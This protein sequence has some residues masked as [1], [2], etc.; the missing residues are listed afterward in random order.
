MNYQ[1]LIKAVASELGQ[2]QTAVKDVLDTAIEEIKQGLVN[3]EDVKI[4]LGTFKVAIQAARKARN[5][6]TGQE[7]EVPEKSVVRFKVNSAVKRLVK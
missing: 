2:T 6:A 3:L 5:P 7:I 1:E 4:P